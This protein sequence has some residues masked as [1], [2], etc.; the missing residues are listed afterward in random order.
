MWI[1]R[2]TQTVL[3]FLK[4]NIPITACANRNLKA[5]S[6]NQERPNVENCGVKEITLKPTE[7][8]NITEFPWWLILVVIVITLIGLIII[9]IL[10]VIFIKF[11]Y[12]KRTKNDNPVRQEKSKF[13]Y[14]TKDLYEDPT[15]LTSGILIKHASWE[16]Q[17]S[18]VKI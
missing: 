16:K 2:K 13:D 1:V 7:T 11:K 5:S 3:L 12:L 10:I 15:Q 6:W 4:K 18:P 8:N 17:I 14:S 9:I